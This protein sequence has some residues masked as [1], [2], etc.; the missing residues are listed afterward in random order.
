MI[1]NY[2]HF[3]SLIIICSSFRTIDLYLFLLLLY[4]L[5]QLLYLFIQFLNE[6]THY[7]IL[8]VEINENTQQFLRLL[9]LITINTSLLLNPLKGILNLL[10]LLST[11]H[12]LI[13]YHSIASCLLLNDIL[14]L[15]DLLL[16]ILQYLLLLLLTLYELLESLIMLDVLV[17]FLALL[18]K[19]LLLSLCLLLQSLKLLL[20]SIST[21]VGLTS[22]LDSLFDTLLL[23]LQFLLQFGVDSS[24]NNQQYNITP[25]QHS[26]PSSI[27]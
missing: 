7:S 14:I 17:E 25:Q 9:I 6:L 3:S 1:Y 27:G 20:C 21:I 26:S 2:F 24:H 10:L 8:L 16:Q 11:Q 4:L 23:F 13:I 5:L 19:V 18:L 22:R 15:L 12:V